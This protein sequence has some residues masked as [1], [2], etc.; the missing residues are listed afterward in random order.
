[1]LIRRILGSIMLLTG[2]AILIVSLAGMYFVGSAIDDIANGIRNTLTLTSQSLNAARNTLD[3]AMETLGGVGEGL[4][5]AVQATGSAAQTMADSRP[6]IGN[7]SGVVTQEIPEAIEGIQGTLPNI[8]QVAA[9]IDNTLGT[10]STIGIDRDIPLPFGG[11]IPLRFDLGIDYNPAVP[12]DES[13]RSF[14]TSLDGLPESLRGLQTDLDSTGEN[15]ATLSND[16]QSATDT[17]A[18]IS[19]QF[20]EIAPLLNQYSLLVDELETTVAQI[21]TDIDQQLRLIQYGAIAVL[22]FLGLTQLAPIYLGWELVTGRRDDASKGL[23]MDG[24]PQDFPTAT[25]LPVAYE[26]AGLLSAME[27]GETL[28]VPTAGITDDQ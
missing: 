3:F 6:L 25:D 21:E 13:L 7:V 8:I 18:G 22:F 11:S 14:Q 20:D 9:V 12:F 23:Q 10:L 2:L 5:A 16:L 27:P 1:M 17:L 28:Q 19:A 15:L 4:A 26:Q 24:H